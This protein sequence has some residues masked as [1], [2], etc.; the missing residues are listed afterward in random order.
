[1]RVGQA[2]GVEKKGQ[3]G[4]GCCREGWHE[5]N[6][7]LYNHRVV[8]KVRERKLVWGLSGKEERRTRATLGRELKGGG[9]RRLFGSYGKSVLLGRGL[10]M[11]SM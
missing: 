6:R 7:Y 11:P 8:E 4:S 10:K 5:V 1:M 9:M 3:T 2:E